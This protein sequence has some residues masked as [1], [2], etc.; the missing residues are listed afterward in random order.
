MQYLQICPQMPPGYPVFHMPAQY[1]EALYDPA[2]DRRVTMVFSEST[3]AER[4]LFIIGLSLI[5]I[6]AVKMT[7]YLISLVLMALILTLLLLPSID[8]LKKKGLSDI[9]AIAVV[10]LSALLIIAVFLFIATLS[11]NSLASDLPLYQKEF[12]ARLTEISQLLSPFGFS[13]NFKESISLD[14]KDLVS[15]FVSGATSFAEGLMFLFFVAV[16][17][18]FMLLEAPHFLARVEKLYGKDTDALRKVARMTQYI[19]DFLVVRTE[20]NAVHGLLFGSFLSL[21][22]V[23]GA[24][25]WGF[26][27]FILGY[28]PYFGLMLAAIPAIFFAWLQFGI[29]GAVAVVV[30]VCILNLIVENPVYSF[31]AARKF[32][33]SA[34][35]VILSVIVWGW[36]LGL[37]GMFFA[38]PLTLILLMVI[39]SSDDLRWINALLGVTHL[40]ET[41]PDIKKE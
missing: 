1:R 3:R 4:I 29:P 41:P 15:V 7:A 22:G 11:F 12:D 33:I 8:W 30:A 18:F 21:M 6:L 2:S 19:I 16:T 14:L 13:G 9:A 20:T 34:L 5:I 31:L 39:E 27:T 32:E 23:H 28:I 26:L 25:L 37:V 24:I 36:L 38:I 35:I 17:T 40:F 10:T